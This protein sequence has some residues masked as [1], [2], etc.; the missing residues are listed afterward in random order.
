[1]NC[2]FADLGLHYFFA[3]FFRWSRLLGA[4]FARTKSR[5][6]FLAQ[7]FLQKIVPKAQKNGAR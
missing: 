4:A 7:L 6:D 5:F 1:L 2:E 3:T